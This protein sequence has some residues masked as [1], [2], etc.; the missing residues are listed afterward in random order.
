MGASL[1]SGRSV[2]DD[3]CAYC[4]HLCGETRRHSGDTALVIYS[5]TPLFI[6]GACWPLFLDTLP[7]ATLAEAWKEA[8]VY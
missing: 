5:L 2:G 3:L 1:D 6:I 8:E 4:L 7:G